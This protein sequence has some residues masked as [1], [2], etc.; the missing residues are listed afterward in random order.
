ML[1]VKDLHVSIEG[2]EILKG[3]N[4]KVNNGEI[5]AFMGPN[6]TGKSTLSAVLMG[7]PKYEI[8]KGEIIF[9]GQVIN[10]LGPD[11]RAK[12]GIFLSFQYPS[13]VE[14]VTI[15][16][17]LRQ[18]LNTKRKSINEEPISVLDFHN[19][20]N[21]KLKLLHALMRK[22]APMLACIAAAYFESSTGI[23]KTMVC[24]SVSGRSLETFQGNISNF[25]SLYELLLNRT[26]GLVENTELFQKNEPNVSGNNY[27]LPIIHNDYFFG[28]IFFGSDD[29][30]CFKEHYL[31]EYDLIGHLIMLLAVDAWKGTHSLV[32]TLRSV[33]SMVS[34]RDPETGIHMERMAFFSKLIAM[35]LSDEQ[36]LDDAFIDNILLFAPL[37]DIGKI[38]ISDE[39]LFKPGRFSEEEFNIMKEHPRIGREMIDS[40]L[41]HHGLLSGPEVEMLRN[42]VEYHHELLDGSGY[43]AGLKGNEI[44]IES[45][46]VAVADIFDAMTSRRPYKD[47]VENSHVYQ[48]LRENAGAKLDQKCVDAL[49]K[50]RDKVEAIQLKFYE[51]IHG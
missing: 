7:H 40:V 35:E 21:E 42:I 12:L 11:E 30:D 4:L 22:K 6:G 26:V 37:H 5:V 18:A 44:P 28:F 34:H 10:D 38:G 15:S 46:I 16:T 41:G 23:L 45:R 50:N 19:L 39:V 20:L 51:N 31:S 27:S 1:E 29:P 14:G 32:A 49:L 17:F 36:G 25:P 13:E 24:S 43:P 9:N 3:V 8:T 48:Y 2:K 47:S 33:Q